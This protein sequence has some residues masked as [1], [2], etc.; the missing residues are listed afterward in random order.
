[1]V[2]EQDVTHTDRQLAQ[3]TEADDVSSEPKEGAAPS[4]V[5]E[6]KQ[7]QPEDKELP[8]PK[9]DELAVT[10]RNVLGITEVEKSLDIKPETSTAMESGPGSQ[11]QA[12]VLTEA[13]SSK[14]TKKKKKKAKQ[15]TDA[16]PEQPVAETPLEPVA[17]PLERIVVP[18]AEPEI[19]ST[20]DAPKEVGVVEADVERN[21]TP[22]ELNTAIETQ[23]PASVPNTRPTSP[24]QVE[25]PVEVP[26]TAAPSVE[27]AT[28][29]PETSTLTAEEAAEIATEEAAIAAL[30]T[31]KA[32]NKKKKLNKTD[33]AELN[34]LEE[35]ARL[36][37][38]AR[39][40][41][42][43][44]IKPEPS[45]GATEQLVLVTEASTAEPPA[46]QTGQP[47][48]E[49]EKVA[50]DAT[51]REAALEPSTTSEHPRSDSPTPRPLTADY[52]QPM[53]DVV[54]AL[55]DPV[56]QMGTVEAIEPVAQTIDTE[57]DIAAQTQLP[58]SVENTRPS[59]PVQEPDV[60]GPLPQESV[61]EPEPSVT[62]PEMPATEVEALRSKPEMSAPEPEQV[63]PGAEV[64][65]E[66]QDENNRAI[67][68]PMETHTQDKELELAAGTHLPV[69]IDSTRPSSPTHEATTSSTAE[70]DKAE[71]LAEVAEE[72][73]AIAAL[74]AKKAGN[75]KKKLN[76]TD[77]AELNRLEERAK[78]REEAKAAVESQTIVQVPSLDQEQTLVAEPVPA[79]KEMEPTT[80]E[81]VETKEEKL[82]D[83]A[84]LQEDNESKQPAIATELPT[85]ELKRPTAEPE[86]FAPL[87]ETME[88]V[89][90]A[91]PEERKELESSPVVDAQ[92]KELPSAADTPLPG[93]LD[94]T[95]PTSPTQ[96][97]AEVM[98]DL[99][100]ETAEEEAAIAALKAK[101]ASN[102]KKKLNKTDQAELTRLEERARLRALQPVPE[103]ATPAVEP[104]MTTAENEQVKGEHEK[105]LGDTDAANPKVTPVVPMEDVKA[106]EPTTK[107]DNSLSHTVL[108]V[109]TERS[110]PVVEPEQPTT[111]D[112]V[113]QPDSG[114]NTRDVTPDTLPV[115][116]DTPDKTL[117]L[118]AETQLEISADNS[119]PSSL[120]PTTE[121]EATPPTVNEPAPSASSKKSKKKKKGNQ[122]TDSEPQTPTFEGLA[123][124]QPPA[125]SPAE[126]TAEAPTQVDQVPGMTKEDE[127]GNDARALEF[128]AGTQLPASAENTRP[129]SPVPPFAEKADEQAVEEQVI[130]SATPSLE[131]S[132]TEGSSKKK[133]KKK[134]SK[135]IDDAELESGTP[136]R[137][138]P[139]TEPDTSKDLDLLP[140]SEAQ[141]IPVD[142]ASLPVEHQPV[143]EV[144][145]LA[146]QHAEIAT[147]EGGNPMLSFEEPSAHQ[148][149]QQ[150]T[151]SRTVETDNKTS[152]TTSSSGT[153]EGPSNDLPSPSQAQ[154]TTGLESDETPEMGGEIQSPEVLAEIAQEEAAIAAL[155]SKKASNK[156][157]KLNKTDQ[158]E[159]NRLEEKA[160]LREVAKAA[161][162]VKITT[163]PAEPPSSDQQ[164]ILIGEPVTEPTEAEKSHA[165]LE[166][167]PKEGETMGE[168]VTQTPLESQINNEPDLTKSET[169]SREL[170]VEEQPV[171]VSE[172]TVTELDSRTA[173]E[174]LE[175]PTGNEPRGLADEETLVEKEAATGTPEIR[176]DDAEKE[177]E[178]ETSPTEPAPKKSKKKKAKKGQLLELEEPSTPTESFSGPQSGTVSAAEPPVEITE[179]IIPTTDDVP[180][181]R[182]YDEA[183]VLGVTTG[184]E[185]KPQEELA[186]AFTAEPVSLD[187]KAVDTQNPSDTS[188]AAGAV[189]IDTPSVPATVQTSTDEPTD[190]IQPIAQNAMDPVIQ[191]SAATVPSETTSIEHGS[192][193]SVDE[194]TTKK[195]KKKKKKGKNAQL[196]ETEGDNSSTV[197]G[198]PAEP[199]E[200]TTTLGLEA[201]Q[202]D[203]LTAPTMKA[204]SSTIDLT[205]T[206]GFEEQ[207]FLTPFEGTTPATAM[208]FVTPFEER[209]AV[210]MEAP[211]AEPTVPVHDL[212]AT[213]TDPADASPASPNTPL[214]DAVK[215]L[216]PEQTQESV[217]DLTLLEAADSV[218]RSARE[219]DEAADI[220]EE[221]AALALLRAK[222][223]KLKKKKKLGQKDQDELNRLETRAKLREEAKA[224]R[225]AEAAA[226]TVASGPQPDASTE[227]TEPANVEQLIPGAMPE[228]PALE[229]PE[230]SRGAFT[231]QDL[232]TSSTEDK[233]ESS[234][235]ASANNEG[236]PEK[237]VEEDAESTPK[238]GLL[239]AALSILPSVG[240]VGSLLGF[241]NSKQEPE[242]ET[243]EKQASSVDHDTSSRQ[244]VKEPAAPANQETRDPT[245]V[246]SQPPAEPQLGESS[247]QG[248]E[249]SG[250][251]AD[252]AANESPEDT[253]TGAI[254]DTA[255]SVPDESTSVAA[256]I[257]DSDVQLAVEDNKPDAPATLLHDVTPP[258][259]E[260][261]PVA[262]DEAPSETTDWANEPSAGKKMGKKGKK[263]KG[264][265]KDDDGAL[266]S[267]VDVTA[268]ELATVDD[269]KEAEPSQEAATVEDAPDSTDDLTTTQA[270][271]VT[272]DDE[273]A[274]STKKGKKGKKNKQKAQAA[275]E[276]PLPESV[277]DPVATASEEAGAP[278]V[279][280]QD[281]TELVSETAKNE[282]AT[283]SPPDDNGTVT[284]QPPET[285]A[286][287]KTKEVDAAVDKVQDEPPAEDTLPEATKKL[288]KK[289]RRKLKQ[290]SQDS[291][292]DLSASEPAEPANEEPPL[293]EA[294]EST[295]D[296]SKQVAAEPSQPDEEVTPPAIDSLE[297]SSEPVDEPQEPVVW[298]EVE[299]APVPAIETSDSLDTAIPEPQEA[300]PEA[301]VTI[302]SEESAP[303]SSDKQPV[304]A[305]AEDVTEEP[306]I[307]GKKKKNKKKKK[308]SGTATPAVEEAVATEEPVVEGTEAAA[309]EVAEVPEVVQTPV[310]EP[311]DVS[312]AE[313]TEATV[314]EPLQAPENLSKEL[315]EPITAEPSAEPS[316]DAAASNVM[317]QEPQEAPV[318]GDDSP[319]DEQSMDKET[320]TTSKGLLPAALSILPS[321][322]AV[323]TLLGLHTD[324]SAAATRSDKPDES[325]TS[326][327]AAAEPVPEESVEPFKSEEKLADNSDLQTSITEESPEPLAEPQTGEVGEAQEAVQPVASEQPTSQQPVE[328]TAEDVW[329]APVSGKKKKKNKKGKKTPE[330]PEPSPT[331]AEHTLE[332][333]TSEEPIAEPSQ[334]EEAS[335]EAQQPAEA[336]PQEPLQQD[337][338]DEPQSGVPEE[339]SRF[340]VDIEP[341]NDTMDI[342]P[343]LPEEQSGT[344]VHDVQEVEAAA[345]QITHLEPPPS[346]PAPAKK[347]SIADL[348]ARF[349]Q[350]AAVEPAK[351][352]RNDKKEM[353]KQIDMEEPQ[354]LSSKAKEIPVPA[355]AV[356]DTPEETDAAIGE[357][358]TIAE[359]SQELA[360]EP[361]VQGSTT[362]QD[363]PAAES[364]EPVTESS[365]G[366]PSDDA[367]MIPP[368]PNVS[369]N[370]ATTEV[371]P[372]IVEEPAEDVAALPSKKSKKKKKGKKG[373]KASD[374]SSEASSEENK[375]SDSTPN[376]PAT[377][378]ISTTQIADGPT[379]MEQVSS[380]MPVEEGT[381]TELIDTAEEPAEAIVEPGQTDISPVPNTEI[382]TESEP[383]VEHQ[384]AKELPVGE[385]VA[386]QDFAAAAASY[387]DTI[388]LEH[389]V[390]ESSVIVQESPQ[391]T[392]TEDQGSKRGYASAGDSA[393]VTTFATAQEGVDQFDKAPSPTTEPTPDTTEQATPVEVSSEANPFG[394]DISAL[395]PTS[396]YS[397]SL[398]NSRERRKRSPEAETR[399]RAASPSSSNGVIV[400]G[401]E[402]RKPDDE[403]EE[404]DLSADSRTSLTSTTLKRSKK[405]RKRSGSQTKQ[406][407][408]DSESPSGLT[409]SEDSWTTPPMPVTQLSTIMEGSTE[410]LRE[411]DNKRVVDTAE[412]EPLPEDTSGKSR[413][414][415]NADD[416]GVR[417]PKDYGTVRDAQADDMAQNAASDTPVDVSSEERDLKVPA[418][419]AAADVASTEDTPTT[420][421][422]GKK[423]KK[424]KKNKKTALPWDEPEP[425]VDSDP[426]VEVTRQESKELVEDVSQE[427]ADTGIDDTVSKTEHRELLEEG[428]ATTEPESSHSVDLPTA[429]E[430]QDIL[431]HPPA[432]PVEEHLVTDAVIFQIDQLEA[433][434]VETLPSAALPIEIETPSLETTAD[435]AASDDKPSTYEPIE[436]VIATEEVNKE[437]GEFQTDEEWAL[438]SKKSKKDKKKKAKKGT[439]TPGE[440]EHQ[441]QP[442]VVEAQPAESSS[443]EETSTPAAPKD[444]S[445]PQ[446]DTSDNQ[447][448][449]AS[450]SQPQETKEELALSA[451]MSEKQKKQAEK[452]VAS[453]AEPAQQPEAVVEE[454]S[455]KTG[456]REEEENPVTTTSESL[457]RVLADIEAVHQPEP[458]ASEEPKEVPVLSLEQP[459]D[460]TPVLKAATPDIPASDGADG[461]LQDRGTT[462]A[463]TEPAADEDEW[464]FPAKKS[465]KDKKKKKKG[466]AAE[467]A[468]SDSMSGT[469][470]PTA[471]DAPV[472]VLEPMTTRER[473]LPASQEIRSSGVVEG[474]PV[475]SLDLT[476]P[477]E[478]TPVDV[479]E[480]LPSQEEE[481]PP[482]PEETKARDV[483]EE[484]SE[485]VQ[486]DAQES[487]KPEPTDNQSLDVQAE[488]EARA[489]APE[490]VGHP[491]GDLPVT[492][493]ILAQIDNLEALPA[494]GVLPVMQFEEPPTPQVEPAVG[495]VVTETTTV[496]PPEPFQQEG[497]V[498]ADD[499]WAVPDKKSKKGKKKNKKGPKASEDSASPSGTQTPTVEEPNPSASV[500]VTAEP[501]VIAGEPAPVAEEASI[502]EVAEKSAPAV[503][504]AHV[505]DPETQPTPEEK[506]T[507]TVDDVTAHEVAE[508]T[509]AASATEKAMPILDAT[510]A[511]EPTPEALPSTEP[512]PDTPTGPDTAV[513][514][515]TQPEE[516][517]AMPSKKSKKDK[518]KKGRQ[519]TSAADSGTA[520][521][522]V[523]ENVVSR[524]LDTAKAE[525]A[526]PADV[527][528]AQAEDEWAETTAKKS[529]KDKK[530]KGKQ[531]AEMLA[532]AAAAVASVI[533]GVS[534]LLS[535]DKETETRP[536][537][538]ASPARSTREVVEPTPQE[539]SEQTT[540]DNSV[541]EP[542]KP[543][544]EP[545]QQEGGGQG[546]PAE[547]VPEPT[548]E[549]MEPPQAEPESV[550]KALVKKG[551]KSLSQL[552]PETATASESKP[553]E[554]PR[555]NDTFEISP[556]ALGF[557]ELSSDQGLKALL[558]G[559]ETANLAASDHPVLP[560]VTLPSPELLTGSPPP[561]EL[562]G[563]PLEAPGPA[564]VPAEETSAT[565]HDVPFD[566]NE[567][568]TRTEN[569]DGADM[570]T[571]RPADKTVEE[572]ATGIPA[573]EE[574]IPVETKPEP[575]PRE[576]AAQL[577]EKPGATGISKA[578]D[579]PVSEAREI[580]A[581]WLESK[582]PPTDRS[583]E[584]GRTEDVPDELQPG[585]SPS[586]EHDGHDNDKATEA[587]AAAGGVALL[588][589][590]F[591]GGS[592]TKKGK[593]E[594]MARELLEEPGLDDAH[595]QEPAVK[596]E[597]SGETKSE[598]DKTTDKDTASVTAEAT[599]RRH[600]TDLNENRNYGSPSRSIPYMSS[601][602]DLRRSLIS[603]PPVQEEEVEEEHGKEQQQHLMR[604]PEVNR[605][606]GFISDSAT[607]RRRSRHY[608]D[609]SHRDSGV[610]LRDWPESTP[611][612]TSRR[613][614][615]AHPA[616]TSGSSLKAE[617]HSY[618]QE[619][620]RS[621]SRQTASIS[622]PEVSRISGSSGLAQTPKL[623][624]PS[625]P[626][627][628]PEPH[629][630]SVK[631]RTATKQLDREPEPAARNVGA[632]LTVPSPAPSERRV[633]SD[634][635]ALHHRGE[636][637]R[638][639]PASSD[640]SMAARRSASNTSMSRL[641]TPEPL[642]LRPD[643]PGS[644]RSLHSATPPLRRNRISGDLRAVS[645]GQRSLSELSASSAATPA[646]KDKGNNK[647]AA[648]AAA[649]LGVGVAAG[650]A[651][652]ALASNSSR[653]SANTTPVANEGRVRSKDMADVYDG[654]GE[655]R[656]GSPR[657]PTR[658]HSMRR[659]QSMQVLDLENKVR[660]LEAENLALSQSRSALE[661]SANPRASG[662]LAERDAT[663]GQLKQNLAFLQKEVER[664]TEVNEGLN[665]ANA[666]IAV[667][668]SERYRDLESKHAD[669]IRELEQARSPTGVL[670]EKD[671]EIARLR[672]QLEEAKQKIRTMQDQILESSP[673]TDAPDYLRSKDVDYFDHRCQQLCNHVQQ[674][675][676]RFSKFSDMRACRLTSEINDEKIIDRLDNAVLDGSDVDTYL[677][678][679]VRRRDIF[680]SMTMTMIWEFIFTRY[681]FG[682]DREQRQKLKSLEKILLEVGPPHA[683]RQWRAITLTLLARRPQFK[684]QRDT[685]TEAVVQAIFQTLSV[686][687]PPPTNMEDQIQSQLRKVM[688]EAV[689]LAIEMRTQR[690]EYMMLP[691]L[692]P[693]YD[694][695]GELTETVSFNA[696]LMNERSDSGTSN[697]D[698]EAAHS[699][700]RIVLFPLVV[701][702]GDD[703]GVGDDEVVVSPAQ[704]L[705]AK[706][707]KKRTIRMVTPSSDAGGASLISRSERMSTASPAGTMRHGNGSDVRMGDAPFI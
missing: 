220:A 288:S 98:P 321:V 441:S 477:V 422:K 417:T 177:I 507:E 128:A 331:A 103:A 212:V 599:I 21:I 528:E 567:T 418:A 308:A 373:S 466:K 538:E 14:K 245:S 517:W 705:V 657:S 590:R 410:D 69:S 652:L 314:T 583:M 237:L 389:P 457:S 553:D 358:G 529:K 593:A 234:R 48:A 207:E 595:E 623:K 350:P 12:E 231:E 687:L 681:L 238:A 506:S 479:S 347:K 340:L 686:I 653:A 335:Q 534:E 707:E 386:V 132:V 174:K 333:P 488:S 498:Q 435:L 460:P 3:A 596:L 11:E 608:E 324:E 201:A 122:N 416:G 549:S 294:S 462:E 182:G 325:N 555:D 163:L 476:P 256:A 255:V 367:D 565:A 300:L 439:S 180:S 145:P 451:N 414:L 685:D 286:L 45:V 124:D 24:V 500:E 392:P 399:P 629:K 344:F 117:D 30:K 501:A 402:A 338:A 601:I 609:D 692:Q 584:E 121:A 209:G 363:V 185:T 312:A 423:G 151:N 520:T 101:K 242:A 249:E 561:K 251:T 138:L 637:L 368:Q 37:E 371:Q 570:E 486:E 119:R 168:T 357:Q 664:L 539:A 384:E 208:D 86:Q 161:R 134:K 438:P 224:L 491:A 319:P 677:N 7:V 412:G 613:D 275:V 16:E 120:P 337:A 426:Q 334:P 667:T 376:Q 40:K 671:A 582:V 616:R 535:D 341:A 150:T 175:P 473:E 689:D 200:T 673:G 330:E 125:I 679:R 545:R 225:E 296:S 68:L 39:S 96:E 463:V 405:D 87:L 650:A 560:P 461:S 396:P 326:P 159:L 270:V 226:S 530:R 592:K 453:L 678:D 359:P 424:A 442:E 4:L 464:A 627:T 375:T 35:R 387:E 433:L 131:E 606:S 34:R 658:P 436:T 393:S 127:V 591:G 105:S 669:A 84:G 413:E 348:I 351:L 690:A 72:E 22:E 683:V 369:L 434:P 216:L 130:E 23:L 19:F 54:V 446:E 210:G 557:T 248:P 546:S 102:K 663:I 449:Q 468:E 515:E 10:D 594:K 381:P 525:P 215:N 536:E 352:S 521:P 179:R 75:K 184:Q 218:I 489:L 437:P 57:R 680:M 397:L 445:E 118:A 484:P 74:K 58:V 181:A 513:E 698:W 531:T 318:T 656:I 372:E 135:Q 6:E 496:I 566:N 285:P 610:H 258:I 116:T 253:T 485:K 80:A 632:P 621:E 158:A 420:G 548:R 682:M 665:S 31:K 133:K 280:S 195:N 232:A 51:V 61:A 160:R 257:H 197:P 243:I 222:K 706:P 189:I 645:L 310:T 578:H 524:E 186:P 428:I 142:Q 108:A 481:V 588:A 383:A 580:A 144:A 504:L 636:S 13:T 199:T 394:E 365:K 620:P 85:V 600:E 214:G 323:G 408:E 95:R 92:E 155:K 674:W 236:T 146:V 266:S 64:K 157:K 649:A 297:A 662:A 259:D 229:T 467:R 281:Q 172:E 252:A 353:D 400:M 459:I 694:D 366:L 666:Q 615:E 173:A 634:H 89:A 421:K 235:E 261:R 36:R 526:A 15:T 342:Q 458:S 398:R 44:E 109:Q 628:T 361:T 543:P 332:E 377:D 148:L 395:L 577:L 162:A 585:V 349:E 1:M 50:A 290:A 178:P 90:E 356:E 646:N 406:N 169:E 309:P 661:H 279:S 444:V 81:L 343:G 703:S 631:K 233:V 295:P 67:D 551:K 523:Q 448:L 254:L 176:K 166:K 147:A 503:D 354:S 322:A 9:D 638:R 407:S 499:E 482:T 164:Q 306:A 112:P 403:E 140:A 648:T 380:T 675:V 156:K 660:E 668:H 440:P 56:V 587:A 305:Y 28:E 364:S 129:S 79:I 415:D 643:S 702:K 469:S 374:V 219:E 427:T 123:A 239:P 602:P 379:P 52:E 619:T 470:T 292:T 552:R 188:V 508:D 672:V 26:G 91:Q 47:V 203:P 691:P 512:Q 317:Q 313:A 360:V 136:T 655:G 320:E 107:D 490:Q 267:A 443:Q 378:E 18:V 391:P 149:E 299:P 66:T 247:G 282:P 612:R 217:D 511:V 2:Q 59:S 495:D 204:E 429:S 193:A 450:G 187:N 574:P 78:L 228:T 113:A 497:H 171:P 221:E 32:N 273:W 126:A 227:P 576:V 271:E 409:L 605:D 518:K 65:S 106:T 556:A 73:A 611:P 626:A 241:T 165:G 699:I 622:T 196:I 385:T 194:P 190:T 152:D 38:E 339:K 419:A 240:V 505:V 302:V 456:T 475:L 572:E 27:E 431:S 532:G 684:Q 483:V 547:V 647:E 287:E 246:D 404:G 293:T 298:K 654:Y 704:V 688:R 607:P 522:A 315:E 527:Q 183:P 139:T 562:L 276:T 452:L 62:Q 278:E 60:S 213:I 336:R 571:R 411:T 494:E 447:E 542:T 563:S 46:T 701:K 167:L 43:A 289:E 370:D 455:A 493:A 697:E 575:S 651:A 676:L 301:A 115:E 700:V 492:D 641:R 211:P 695:T 191:E 639:S 633:V 487:I 696:A 70:D 516:L 597:R 269:T 274:V 502:T 598:E 33:Q 93:S 5:E 569:D 268:P 603:L 205:P 564:L 17:E 589:K 291:S 143:T 345:E 304:E 260:Q 230:Q 104:E 202:E 53:P 617:T 614:L 355:M 42:I 277:S 272:A 454:P 114:I 533:P 465:K 540:P 401:R 198:T 110:T 284:E 25:E 82:K 223:A 20:P 624:E 430:A 262:I 154:P 329:E 100:A 604:T 382:A 630:I 579:E 244:E 170:H 307:T 94:T 581:S 99:V 541:P 568:H 510:P 519:S 514:P 559:I 544:A 41:Q 303:A 425:G 192:N 153:Q 283:D 206:P 670:R 83:I 111:D 137:D 586:S 573:T 265:A 471:E 97:A 362:H 509:D 29:I 554:K 250:P 390:T 625:P 71:V 635:S 263:G 642:N 480:Q 693:E 644:V 346:A 550:W 328:A 55:E 388:K 63:I 264:K 141:A 558:P 49:A 618:H 316:I 659:R 77:Q 327:D 311:V 537:M 76:K 8:L 474:A 432:I 88:S 640:L 478:N 472:E